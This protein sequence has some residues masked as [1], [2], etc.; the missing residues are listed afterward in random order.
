MICGSTLWKC[1]PDKYMFHTEFCGSEKE[2]ICFIS[3]INVDKIID[4]EG[5]LPNVVRFLD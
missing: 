2:D 4:E 3:E 1:T 5:Q